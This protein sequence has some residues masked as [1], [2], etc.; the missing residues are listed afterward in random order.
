[1]SEWIRIND[2]L[3]EYDKWVLIYTEKGWM[4]V[5]RRFNDIDGSPFEWISEHAEFID[6][7]W[8]THWQDL[9]EP[10]MDNQRSYPAPEI[11]M[12]AGQ[13]KLHID[14]PGRRL[15]K[16]FKRDLG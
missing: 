16:I 8:V 6:S 11:A 4:G 13:E 12:N 3:P 15:V 2:R 9:P 1:M 10:P 7:R 14:M 5:A